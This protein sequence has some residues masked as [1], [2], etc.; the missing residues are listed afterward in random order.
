MTTSLY[1]Y[2]QRALRVAPKPLV[3]AIALIAASAG[4][5][6]LAGTLIGPG[7][8]ATVGASS[9]VESWTLRDGAS[10]NVTPGGQTNAISA[11]AGASVAIVGG[12]VNASSSTPALTLSD[13]AATLNGAA[14]TNTT[15]SALSLNRAPGNVGLAN[16]SAQIANSTI[17]GAG[18]A[19]STFAGATLKLANTQINATRNGSGML[20]S[21]IGGTLLGGN[22]SATN[23][24]HIAGD[25]NG[26]LVSAERQ[27]N[28]DW[29]TD[30]HLDQSVV[31]G[32]SGAAIV[33]DSLIPSFPS[34][35]ANI[36]VSN[37]SNLIG[38]NGNL[39]EV[40]NGNTANLTVDNS[41]LTGNVV[42]DA[43]ST[44]AVTLQNN[45][46][47]TGQ[48]TNVGNLAVNS[49]A[50]WNMVADASV[51]T[52]TMNG[53][54]VA[55]SDGSGARFHTLTLDSLSGNGTFH[56]GTDVAAHT[57]DFLNV[58]GNATGDFSLDIRN[59]G[60]EPAKGGQPLQVV[61]TGSGDATFEV[62][63][64]K[65][66]A[67]TYQYQLNQQGNDW[68]LVQKVDDTGAPVITPST[69]SVLGLFNASSTIWYGEQASLRSRMGD[70]RLGKNTDDV[71]VRTYG[72]RYL[73]SAGN[74]LAYQ[75][76]QYG[77]SFGADTAVPV[78]SGRVRVGVLG[79]YSRNDLDFGSATT[80]SIDSFSVGGYATWLADNGVYV[81][82]VLKGN[83]F[84]NNAK[85]VMSD[86]TPAQGSY[87]NYGIG[88]SVEVGRQIQL[89][90]GWF[91]EPSIGLSAMTA[92]GATTVLDNGL[93]AAGSANKSVQARVG[94]TLGRTIQRADGGVLQPYVKAAVVQ[95]FARGN[96][97]KVNDNRFD[98]NLYGTR[99]E[100][101]VGLVAAL[102]RRLHLN[103]DVLYSKGDKIEQPFGV[104]LGM[105]YVW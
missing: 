99:A 77:L 28:L 50:T 101:G 14:I 80:G 64:G 105:R 45:A 10:L 54:N 46:T 62:V 57:G 59:T 20:N 95:E 92:S 17:A 82:G 5:L 40:N 85:I 18:V 55:L 79:G 1:P 36:T 75:H 16:A 26:L 66:D 90:D 88:T 96:D 74:S 67:G 35:T 7:A 91:V 39:L 25:A 78:A 42:A 41:A 104:N 73:V 44:A 56:L 27:T 61:H 81:D 29:V 33:V 15:G 4:Q 94:A 34:A 13:S 38:G 72:N 21:G 98:N 70:L 68:Y 63:G 84:R 43:T 97:V 103:A 19:V 60:V 89:A 53:G 8:S 83:V 86:G 93:R 100:V 47:L 3:A 87:T 23:G 102:S 37:G 30:L 11:V 51:P 49:N 48:L 32:R 65:V 69:Q 22:V 2:R 12:S 24:T 58:T 31:E 71:W 9:P 52:L 76:N 6:A